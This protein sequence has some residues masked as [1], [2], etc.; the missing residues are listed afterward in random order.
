MRRSDWTARCGSVL[1]LA[2]RDYHSHGVPLVTSGAA[3]NRKSAERSLRNLEADG[4]ISIA[5]R[6]EGVRLTEYG[7]SFARR[8]CGA[9]SLADSAAAVDRARL[10]GSMPDFGPLA[11]RIVCPE[12]R[13]TTPPE[14]E[15]YSLAAA[16]LWHA[17]SDLEELFFPA[18]VHGWCEAWSD[19]RGHVF[20]VPLD[21]AAE[22]K[23][24]DLG[25]LQPEEAAI[26]VYYGELAEYR[27]HLRMSEPS[28]PGEVSYYPLPASWEL[29]PCRPRES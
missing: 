25:D 27:A 22:F 18:L 24:F 21:A 7:D 12:V 9:P 5:A 29:T 23:Q 4:L 28:M 13:L 2:R 14:P 1:Y 16:D 17:V 3:A 11:G 6:R 19:M 26:D 10:L 20:Y 15:V 8:L